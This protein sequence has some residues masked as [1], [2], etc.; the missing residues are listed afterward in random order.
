MVGP[1]QPCGGGREEGVSYVLELGKEAVTCTRTRKIRERV[2]YAELTCVSSPEPLLDDELGW[3]AL[4]QSHI[5]VYLPF[6]ISQE[7]TCV[8]VFQTGRR[9]PHSGE[10][11]LRPM[12][13]V[14]PAGH[15]VPYS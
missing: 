7:M 4:P 14:L 11:R 1:E 3:K 2:R 9:S 5:G 10:A 12:A 15:T 6:I 8:C 13:K